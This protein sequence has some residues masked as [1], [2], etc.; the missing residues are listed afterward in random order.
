[1]AD[2]SRF[3]VTGN[4]LHERL[5]KVFADHLAPDTPHFGGGGLGY[6]GVRLE[7]IAPDGSKL[8]LIVTLRAGAV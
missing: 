5:T 8:D 3:D 4:D 2:S 7:N 6:Y 1:M